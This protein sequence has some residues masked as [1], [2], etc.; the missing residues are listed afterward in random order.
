MQNFE[1]KI[2][3]SL[4]AIKNPTMDKIMLFLSSLSNHGEIWIAIGILSCLAYIF[5]S[6]K[7]MA[8][9]IPLQ[10]ERSAH[11][12]R[13][14]QPERKGNVGLMILLALLFSFLLTNLVLKPLVAR[15]RPYDIAQVKLLVERLSDYS[16]P[17]GHTSA[18]FAAAVA[19]WFWDR[20]WG[21]LAILLAALIAFSRLYLYVH[22]PTDILG[23]IVVGVLCGYLANRL[24]RLRSRM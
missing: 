13:K 4:S 7:Q 10:F 5:L 11:Y 8:S 16:F 19:I 1:L 18:S 6:R 21:A 9:N 14:P 15:T 24:Y 2:L 3:D 12:H 22:F 20:K 23:G 17:S